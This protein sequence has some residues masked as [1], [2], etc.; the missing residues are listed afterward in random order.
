[1]TPTRDTRPVSELSE[2][3]RRQLAQR[4]EQL[5][6]QT[7]RDGLAEGDPLCEGLADLATFNAE[8]QLGGRL[9]PKP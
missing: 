9:T 3:E 8:A 5:I 1:M 7:F 6:K 4:M 2:D